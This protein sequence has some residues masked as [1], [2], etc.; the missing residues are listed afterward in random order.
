MEREKNYNLLCVGTALVDSIV[1]GFDP[2][3]VSAAGYRAESGSLHVGGEAVN[4]S[5][6]AAKLTEKVGILCYLGMDAAGD[7]VEGMLSRAGVDTSCIVRECGHATPVSTLF[8][9]ADGSRKSI[10]NGA[11]RYNFHPE[12]YREALQSAR[13]VSLGS[14]FRAPF[15]DPEVIRETLNAVQGAIVFA[16][17]K[18]PNFTRLVLEDVRESLKRIDYIFPNEDE[19]KHFTGCDDPDDAADVLL[20]CGVKNVI[21]K[22]GGEGCLFKNA[23][24]RI[25][26][27]AFSVK[28][29]DAVGAGDCF[30]AG[31]AA[32][33]LEGAT[34]FEALRFASACGAACCT[35][36]GA[37]AGITSR[38]QVERLLRAE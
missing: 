8:V 10:T 9:H 13:A 20:A 34:H 31:F 37:T 4:A 1:R 7:M 15:D 5:V 11:H 19:A 27:P 3:P 14:L 21:V 38:E 18:L 12:R 23:K 16:D 25:R 30:L 6:A 32:R 17:T 36:V 26:M 35:A 33:I 22:L 2:T 29:L 24:E 28:V